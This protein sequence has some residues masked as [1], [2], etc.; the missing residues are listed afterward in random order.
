MWQLGTLHQ[1]LVKYAERAACTVPFTVTT[2][3]FET[4]PVMYYNH[5][6]PTAKLYLEQSV[7]LLCIYWSKLIGKGRLKSRPLFLIPY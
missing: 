5:E 6:T 2:G 1:D 4:I 7:K 3:E